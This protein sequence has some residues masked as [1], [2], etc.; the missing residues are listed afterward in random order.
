VVKGENDR[1]TARRIFI[2]IP[3]VESGCWT[4]LVI[5][6][7]SEA[8]WLILPCALDTCEYL[9]ASR[10]NHRMVRYAQVLNKWLSASWKPNTNYSIEIYRGLYERLHGHVDSGCYLLAIFDF[11]YNNCPTQLKVDDVEN[12]RKVLCFSIFHGQY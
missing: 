5:D 9:E 6:C 3:D 11:L 2:P 7:V 10:V 8:I 1:V 4:G 12:Y